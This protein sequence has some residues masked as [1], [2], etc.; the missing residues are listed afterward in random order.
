MP[1]QHW[2]DEGMDEAAV[3]ARV[4]EA[5]DGII[6]HRHSGY[7]LI[8]SFPM[9]R[10]LDI[11]ISAFAEAMPRQ[12]NNIITTTNC[13]GE[14]EWAGTRALE[15][16]A[17]FMAAELLG[18]ADPAANADG[19]IC[20]GGTEAN[21]QGMWLGRNR[22]REQGCRRIGIIASCEA[23]YSVMKGSD[24]LGIGL[25]NA[26]AEPLPRGWLRIRRERGHS[27][28]ALC[29]VRPDGG[30]D[31]ASM[32]MELDAML[33][34]GFDGIILVANAGSSHIGAVDDVNGM[35]GLLR[36][37]RQRYPALAWHVHV[38]AAFGGLAL[39]FSE[40]NPGG[41]DFANPAVDSI[42]IDPHK[43]GRTPAPAGM[44][45]CRKGQLDS[46][47]R[48]VS[49]LHEGRDDTISG[50]R[51]GAAA[52]AC[53]AAF[54]A[55]GRSGYRRQFE[56]MMQLKQ[57]LLHGLAG[58][59]QLKVI[60]SPQNT[61]G[62]HIGDDVD[63]DTRGRLTDLFNDHSRYVLRWSHVFAF[64]REGWQY[65]RP[66]YKVLVMPHLDESKVERF[67]SDISEV[68]ETRS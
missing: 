12:P 68:I 42:T 60:D 47:C 55:M 25:E 18:M 36:E 7:P 19:Y 10:P 56:E 51:S 27:G 5:L 64:A 13:D 21:L 48:M 1:E 28:L 39:P 32:R 59:P 33:R 22:L 43:F 45:I 46:V 30:I 58:F 41:W 11:A 50:S 38:D 23:H 63:D 4:R 31:L 6:D 67:L 52:V 40:H 61:F 44:F 15:R 65:C 35:L 53:W 26:K 54:R 49:Y 3:L 34:E 16:E 9:T 62:F 66:V 2:P 57:Q 17:V 14:P 24:L 20:P 29:S 8:L 37:Y